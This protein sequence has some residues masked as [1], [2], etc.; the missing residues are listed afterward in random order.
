[1]TFPRTSGSALELL[2][3]PGLDAEELRN[4]LRDVGR[5]NRW[6]GGTQAVIDE[7]ER[8]VTKRSLHGA[9]TVLD[10]GSGGADIPRALVRW[11]ERRGLRVQVVAC[12]W[13]PQIPAIA[14]GFSRS[15]GSIS[16]L[17][18]DALALPLPDGGFDFVTCS[19][20]LHHLGEEEVVSLLRKQRA[21]PRH[22]LI[23]CDLERSRLGVAG[24]WLA[25]RVVCRSR[26]TRHDASLSVRRAYTLTELQDLARRAGCADMRWCRSRFFRIVGVLEK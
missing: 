26:L 9:I 3:L 13:H 18:A 10:V 17:R 20:M 12:D 4:S 24:V 11:G 23:V 14:A 8:I 5:L 1:M 7:I 16:F 25:A 6:F 21:L 22:G 2:D 15:N 19:L